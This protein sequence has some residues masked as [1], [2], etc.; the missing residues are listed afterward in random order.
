MISRRAV[1]IFRGVMEESG[2]APV[3]DLGQRLFVLLVIV[4]PN[5]LGC[6]VFDHIYVSI[7]TEN[8]KITALTR[9]DRCANKKSCK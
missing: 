9:I 4:V 2:A 7:R 8:R 6:A 3:T 1:H 5:I